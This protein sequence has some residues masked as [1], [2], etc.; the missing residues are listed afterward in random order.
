MTVDFTTDANRDGNFVPTLLAVSSDD[1]VTPVKVAAD[2]DTGRILVD[3]ASGGLAFLAATGTVNGVNA[4]FTFAA[5]PSVIVVDQGRSMQKVSSDGTINWT[6][7]T[8]VVLTIA[9]NFDIFGLG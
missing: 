1:G 7:T 6:G 3:I 4:T 8:S 2:P 9:P 5:A